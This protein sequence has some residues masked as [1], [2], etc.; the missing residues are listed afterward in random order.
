V[1]RMV[2]I[3]DDLTCAASCS[4]CCR[5][6]S[7]AS[8]TSGSSQTVNAPRC[9]R[10]AVGCSEALSRQPLRRHR[11]LLTTLIHSGVV[12]YAVAPCTW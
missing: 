6:A 4:T 11:C 1:A 10:G 2:V 7:C 5:R 8:A 12:R 3:A 9:C